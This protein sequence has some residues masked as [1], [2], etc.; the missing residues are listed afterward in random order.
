MR[1]PDPDDTVTIWRPGD[2]KPERYSVEPGYRFTWMIK[3]KS[4]S[5]V[6]IKTTVVDTP[7]P[8]CGRTAIVPLPPTLLAQQPD[9][10]T[11]VCH[12]LFYGCNHGFERKP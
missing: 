8:M 5:S 7:C 4:G 12:P 1:S 9:K 10:T 2:P 11:H 6:G 3:T